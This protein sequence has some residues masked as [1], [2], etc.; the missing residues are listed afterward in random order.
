MPFTSSLFLSSL[1]VRNTE[2]SNR[3]H[4]KVKVW[5][6]F[7]KE[8]GAKAF[9]EMNYFL[10]AFWYSQALEAAPTDATLLS[11]RSACYARMQR[12]SEALRDATECISLRP[13]WPKAYYRA[14]AALNIL[15]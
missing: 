10:A 2:L 11:N 1:T 7:F 14:G 4:L 15:K 8:N 9:Q 5:G 6:S 13:D 3:G 12:G